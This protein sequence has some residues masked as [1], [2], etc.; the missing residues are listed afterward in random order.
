ME[1]VGRSWCRVSSVVHVTGSVSL[2]LLLQVECNVGTLGSS[3]M[4][5]D[6]GGVTEV[7]RVC[8]EALADVQRVAGGLLAAKGRVL[9]S[10]SVLLCE[11]A[12][13]LPCLGPVQ[14]LLDLD[15]GMADLLAQQ[16]DVG[17]TLAAAIK[18]LTPRPR[19]ALG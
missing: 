7:A 10:H 17:L 18:R 3:S 1:R 9:T 14:A 4:S 15:A 16:E 6:T 13:V 12:P 19:H 8:L 2:P 5:G 11:T